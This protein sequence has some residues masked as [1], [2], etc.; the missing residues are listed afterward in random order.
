LAT[1]LQGVSYTGA[2][3]YHQQHLYRGRRRGAL[4]SSADAITWTALASGVAN[5]LNAVQFGGAK[6][7]VVAMQGKFW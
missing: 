5:N 3:E 2:G 1:A 4:Y 7:V 6:F